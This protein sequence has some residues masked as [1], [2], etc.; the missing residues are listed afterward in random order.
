M[1]VEGFASGLA[2][3]SSDSGELPYVT[4]DAGIVAAEKDSAAWI[5]TLERLLQDS[6]L[7]A[8]FAERGRA[9]H[10]R[11]FYLA[12]Y[13]AAAYRVL[14]GASGYADDGYHIRPTNCL[15]SEYRYWPSR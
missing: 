14:R 6:E 11:A 12:D 15:I 9:R 10:R 5:D 13:R 7:R 1:I 4:G 8:D 3:V 2:V